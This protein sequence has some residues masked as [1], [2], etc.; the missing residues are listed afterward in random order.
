MQAIDK[1]IAE[2]RL[3][4]VPHYLTDAWLADCTLFGS[5]KRVREELEGWYAAGVRTPIVVPSS[6]AGNQMKAIEEMFTA[7]AD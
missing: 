3:S 4:D 2:K 1:A 5:A 6:A 7:F